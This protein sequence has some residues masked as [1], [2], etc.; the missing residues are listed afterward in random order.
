M[1]LDGLLT[2]KEFGNCIC[3]IKLNSGLFGKKP[4]GIDI[5]E[6]GIRLVFKSGEQLYSYSDITAIKSMDYFYPNPITY[7]FDIFQA[8]KKIASV[9]IPYVNRIVG[10]QL[11][12]AHKNAVLGSDFPENLSTTAYALDEYLSWEKNKLVYNGRKGKEEYPP[13]QIDSFISKDGCYFFTLKNSN[14]TIGILLHN[15]P[16]CLMAIELC[17][18]IAAMK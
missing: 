14:K 12:T 11:L 9:A 1:S 5:F 4:A 13:E 16:N 3:Q 15:S 7:N 2:N 17:T 6:N 10:T 8:D 18:A